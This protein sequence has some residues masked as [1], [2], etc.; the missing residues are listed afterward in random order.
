MKK[1]FKSIDFDLANHA[2]VFP[3]THTHS[4]TGWVSFDWSGSYEITIYLC[5]HSSYYVFV[6]VC[7]YKDTR[8]CNSFK[9]LK[10]L[11]ISNMKNIIL[12]VFNP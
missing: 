8:S 11:R 10:F 9:Y 4:S 3:S 5:I 12:F 1:A 6:F 2:L 7:L